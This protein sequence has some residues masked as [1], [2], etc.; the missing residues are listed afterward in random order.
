M[1]KQLEIDSCTLLVPAKKGEL[2]SIDGLTASMKGKFGFINEAETEGTPEKRS[3][4][5]EVEN[6]QKWVVRTFILT[7]GYLYVL[8]LRK[9]NMIGG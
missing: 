7:I 9:I 6:Q 8:A 2:E 3:R 5:A 4:T 1:A